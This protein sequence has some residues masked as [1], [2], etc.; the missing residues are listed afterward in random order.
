MKVLFNISCV[1]LK[2]RGSKN[3]LNFQFSLEH[4]FCY[5][6]F[7]FSKTCVSD[8]QCPTE[9]LTEILHITRS[10]FGTKVMQERSRIWPG[11]KWLIVEM[12]WRN[13]IKEINL[14]YLHKHLIIRQKHTCTHWKTLVEFIIY[15]T[16]V[17][18]L[19]CKNNFSCFELI[20]ALFLIK[21]YIRTIVQHWGW[22]QKQIKE[23]KRVL[24]VYFK[25]TKEQKPSHYVATQWVFERTR[26]WYNDVIVRKVYF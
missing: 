11:G 2:S 24:A 7:C 18:C 26:H 19:S 13:L 4:C 3:A 21:L 23:R 1:V 20:S 9:Y 6:N 25:P 22:K 15:S 17:I 5:N 12:L 8:P 10:N 14:N 16:S